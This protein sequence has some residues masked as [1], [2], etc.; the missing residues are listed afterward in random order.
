MTERELRLAQKALFN[1][2]EHIAEAGLRLEDTKYESDYR[3]LWNAL[4]SLNNRLVNDIR[5][6]K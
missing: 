6:G 1:G 3:K 2:G 4:E 5:G